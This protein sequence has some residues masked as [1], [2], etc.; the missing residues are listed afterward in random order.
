M[1]QY[2][3]PPPP[4]EPQRRGTPGW[5]WALAGCGGCAVVALIVVVVASVFITRTVQQAFDTGP[6]DRAS[7]QQAFG[8]DVPLYPGSTVDEDATRII[9]GSLKLVGSLAGSELEAASL[10]TS[11]APEEIYAFYD[12]RLPK[13][14]WKRLEQAPAADQDTRVYEK[15]ELQIHLTV[16]QDENNPA[17]TQILMMRG[18]AK[19]LKDVGSSDTPP[20]GNPEEEA[21]S[22]NAPGT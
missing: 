2:P 12:E 14:G 22:A 8:S 6:V 4:A 20:E 11:D 13:L 15:G 21:P 18:P 7:I 1:S 10:Q 3:G 5:V 16:T 19:L 9:R 17:S